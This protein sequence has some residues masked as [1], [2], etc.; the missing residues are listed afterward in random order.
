M[1]AGGDAVRTAW[2]GRGQRACELQA[3]RSSKRN[4]VPCRLLPM[5]QTA[6]AWPAPPP[7]P[8]RP[9][10]DHAL[11]LR[12]LAAARAKAASRHDAAGDAVLAARL[13][14]VRGQDAWWQCL[15]VGK[16]GG[17]SQWTGAA[18]L[19]EQSSMAVWFKL[20]ASSQHHSLSTVLRAPAGGQLPK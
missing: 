15:A 13:K 6:V 19:V 11:Q 20:A 3:D 8:C 4:L 7:V 12:A 1:G 5:Q 2:A 9:E 17:V 16:R 10:K 18:S 14:L